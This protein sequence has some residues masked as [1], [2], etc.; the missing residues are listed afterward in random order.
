[1]ESD[2]AFSNDLARQVREQSNLCLE[3]VAQASDVSAKAISRYE[4]GERE[5][6]LRYFRALWL[7]TRDMRLLRYLDCDLPRQL[8]TAGSTAESPA[9]PQAPARRTPPAGDP[10]DL[11][12]RELKAVE[13]LVAAAQYVQRIVVDG[14]VDESDHTAI[15]NLM[16]KH[17]EV[18]AIVDACDRAL[19]QYREQSPERDRR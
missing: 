11:L 13:E 16:A 7:L 1:M 3:V 6:T 15:G 9:Q 4:H 10:R 18:R 8:Q 12:A 19:M 17:D 5:L 2:M 14:H